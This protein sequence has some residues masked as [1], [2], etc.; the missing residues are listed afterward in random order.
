MIL[1]DLYCLVDDFFKE[2]MPEWYASLL[3]NQIRRKPWSCQMSPNEIMVITILFHRQQYRN[4]K[5]FYLMHV[6]KQMENDFPKLLSDSRFVEQ[7]QSIT[8]ST[9]TVTF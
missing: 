1:E 9:G 7:M 2:F 4:F 6:Q 8:L 5:E 3:E